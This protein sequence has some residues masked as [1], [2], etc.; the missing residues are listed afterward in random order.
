LPLSRRFHRAGTA[1]VAVFLGI[2][3]AGSV[4]EA[5]GSDSDCVVGDRSYRIVLPTGHDAGTPIG[6]II[7]AHG[8]RGTAGGVMRNKNLTGLAEELGV[9]FVAVQ[10]AGAD[11]NLPGVPGGNVPADVDE[12]A[13]FDALSADLAGRFGVEQARTLVTGFSAGGMMTWYLACYRSDAYAGFAPMSGTFWEPLPQNCPSGP[14]DLIH[15]HGD[16]D[17]V[18]PLKGRPI[19]ETHQGDVYKALAMIELTGD[20]RPVETEQTEGLDC[21]RKVD[22]DGRMVEFCLFSGGHQIKASHLSRAW[23]VLAAPRASQ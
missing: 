19:N 17:P 9:A 15:Y 1:L 3:F 12:L 4:A 13:Y 8:Y 20:Y 23:Q 22:A 16:Q 2:T 6:A 21:T 14:V 7:F 11:W 10:A 18:V 5:C